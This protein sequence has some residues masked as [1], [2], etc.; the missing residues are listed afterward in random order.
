MS[1]WSRLGPNSIWFH[2]WYDFVMDEPDV[3]ADGFAKY[4]CR[5]HAELRPV[6]IVLQA[7]EERDFGPA[8]MLNGKRPMDPEFVEVKPVKNVKCPGQ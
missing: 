3:Y 1:N 6:S 2:D 8:D 4:L 5:E 7:V